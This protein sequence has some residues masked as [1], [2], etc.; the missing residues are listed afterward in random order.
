[1]PQTQTYGLLAAIGF[2]FS[3]ALLG[4]VNFSAVMYAALAAFLPASVQ[5]AWPPQLPPSQIAVVL[6]TAACTTAVVWLVTPRRANRHLPYRHRAPAWVIQTLFGL[7]TAWFV[8]ELVHLVAHP[9]L[10]QQRYRLEQAGSLA[11]AVTLVL[12]LY[13]ANGLGPYLGLKTEFSMAMFSNL[14]CRGWNHLLLP[15][16]SARAFS[17]FQSR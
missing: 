1:M 10:G 14:R 16:S 3:L 2:H 17:I 6:L 12:A 5:N 11:P 7:L 8:L 13:A 4:I 15:G 9:A